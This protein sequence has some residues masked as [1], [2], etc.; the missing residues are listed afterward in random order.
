[1]LSILLRGAFEIGGC[2]GV[3]VKRLINRY[4]R[5]AQAPLLPQCLIEIFDQVVCVFETDR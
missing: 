3:C 2:R 5:L 1:M 4:G